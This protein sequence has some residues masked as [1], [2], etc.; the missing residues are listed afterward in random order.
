[1]FYFLLNSLLYLF[2]GGAALTASLASYL[3]FAQPDFHFPKPTGDYA[4]GTKTYHLLDE[5]YENAQGDEVG[6]ELMVQAWYPAQG[7]LAEDATVPYAP[8]LV[9]Y[10][11]KNHKRIW[12]LTSSRPMYTYAVP[13]AEIAS[14]EQCFPVLIFSHGLGCTR[15]HGTAFCEELASQGYFVLG[16]SHSVGGSVVQF[17]DGRVIETGSTEDLK[18]FLQ[19][20]MNTLNR[21]NKNLELWV[22]EVQFVLDQLEKMA[23]DQE[24]F[25]YDHIDIDNIGMFGHSFGGATTVQLCCR[26]ARIRAGVNMDGPLFGEQPTLGFDKPFMFLLRAQKGMDRVARLVELG[27]KRHIAQEYAQ[28]KDEMYLPAIDQLIEEIGHDVYKIHIVD[29]GHNAF[30][31][32]ALR[33]E[34]SLLSK[35][36]GH[37]GVGSINGFTAIELVNTY[38][39]SFFDKYLKG[40]D[41]SLLPEKEVKLVA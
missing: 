11:K 27:M 16:I 33:R 20:P 17:P 18:S 13:D 7:E 38:L 1:M 19:D 28:A 40:E 4:V 35:Y 6:K 26:D 2:G 21:Q 5:N 22:N 9:D 3:A 39:V 37:I 23:V 15:N 25:L 29:A 24:S 32:V 34:A 31:D 36:F 41:S 10:L 8:Y 30:C 14:G 12:L